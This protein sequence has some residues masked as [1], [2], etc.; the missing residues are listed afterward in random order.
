MTS[1]MQIMPELQEIS[2]EAASLKV[3]SIGTSMV[4]DITDV[5][6]DLQKLCGEPSVVMPK[7]MGPLGVLTVPV[8]LSSP[9]LVVPLGGEIGEVVRRHLIPRL[10]LQKSSATYSSV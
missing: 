6:L 8:T 9:L 3:V 7:E 10:S 4:V 2:G 5:V 1:V